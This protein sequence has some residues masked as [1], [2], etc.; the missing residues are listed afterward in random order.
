MPAK[1]TIL[2][3]GPSGSGKSYCLRNLKPDQTLLIDT[4]RKG[5]P[6]LGAKKFAVECETHQAVLDQIKNTTKPIVVLDSFSAYGDLL[7]EHCRKIYKG[8]DIFNGVSNGISELFKVVAD[9]GVIFAMTAIDEVVYIDQAEGAR[10]SR[11]RVKIMGKV[12]EGQVEKKFLVVVFNDPIK[13]KDGT[14]QF[15][16]NTQTDGVT[17]AKS[18]PWLGLTRHI[19][20]DLQLI[21]DAVKKHEN[22][23]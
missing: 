12:W 20:N 10:V 7:Y 5:F 19:D 1:P 15:R 3:V 21:L 18:P 8:F 11:S 4:E 13:N 6:F 16:F 22:D 23:L 14:I 9:K 17:S 2:I